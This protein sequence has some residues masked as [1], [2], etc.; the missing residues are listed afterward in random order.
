MA[1]IDK[2]NMTKTQGREYWN[3]MLDH[4]DKC[5]LLAGTL[6]YGSFYKTDSGYQTNNIEST[7]WYLWHYC[8]LDFVQERLR[9]QYGDTPPRN[10]Y[11]ETIDSLVENYGKNVYDVL[12]LM[13]NYGCDNAR[14]EIIRRLHKETTK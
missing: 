3:W 9:Q 1:G 8:K 6:L 5:E 7:D 4:I 12:G 11:S 14:F 2:I 10:V 13:D